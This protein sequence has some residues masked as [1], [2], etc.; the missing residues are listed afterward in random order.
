LVKVRFNTQH[1]CP[2]NGGT[3]GVDRIRDQIQ[4]DLLKLDRVA[5]NRRQLSAEFGLNGDATKLHLGLNVA[6]HLPDKLVH[7]QRNAFPSALLEHHS[8]AV[9]HLAGTMTVTDNAF[10]RRSRL[11]EIRTGPVEPT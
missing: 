8:D 4:Y 3:H 7:V 10:Q 5:G 1:A 11:V 6:E 2:V 9:D